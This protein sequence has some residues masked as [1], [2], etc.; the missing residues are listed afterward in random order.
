MAPDGRIPLLVLGLGNLLCGDDGLGP[1]AVSVLTR[2]FEIPEGVRVL[3][4]GTLG[5]V[6]A[7]VHRGCSST[8]F[9]S[10][11]C[12]PISLPGSFVRLEGDDVAPAVRNR[13]SVHQIGVADLLDG[14]RWRGRYPARLTL[15]GLV[16][17]TL[18]LGL[19]RSAV[20]DAGLPAL[21]ER[22]VS[23]ARALGYEFRPKAS[24]DT[25]LSRSAGDVPR[26]FGLP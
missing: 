16:P 10:T 18:E 11:P 9:W 4:G 5:L 23:E 15:L 12:A 22:I 6:L 14:A 21:I 26:A 3:D 19:E 1:A 17:E 24:D 13:L 2:A 20:V 7:A 8:F 25:G